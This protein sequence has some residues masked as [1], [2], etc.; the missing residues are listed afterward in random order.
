M[1]TDKLCIK[2]TR[3]TRY[4]ALFISVLMKRK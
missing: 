3:L 1:K 2:L 4:I